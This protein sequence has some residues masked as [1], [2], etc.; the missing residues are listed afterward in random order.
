MF[1]LLNELLNELSNSLFVYCELFKFFLSEFSVLFRSE[2]S[3][4]LLIDDLFWKFGSDGGG[5]DDW[6]SFFRRKIGGGVRGGD[7]GRWPGGCK[8]DVASVELVLQQLLARRG[9]G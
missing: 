7:I 8:L 5:V 4:E 1:V 3:S 2:L 6:F 9:P